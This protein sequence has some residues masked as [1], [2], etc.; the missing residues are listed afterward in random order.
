MA[1]ILFLSQLV[2][3]FVAIRLEKVSMKLGSGNFV[4]IMSQ[5]YY[6]FVFGTQE[7]FNTFF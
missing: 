7:G 4:K 5:L 2:L 3:H 1:L 6:V